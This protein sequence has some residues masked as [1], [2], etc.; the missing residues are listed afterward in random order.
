MP[1]EIPRLRIQANERRGAT[2]LLSIPFILPLFG[3]LFLMT[4]GV[5]G[6]SAPPSSGGA[7]PMEG[8][9]QQPTFDLQISK[10]DGVYYVTPGTVITYTI[11]YTNTWSSESPPFHVIECPPFNANVQGEENPDWTYKAP[12]YWRYPATD[13]SLAGGAS[14]SIAFTI[15]VPLAA[16]YG[17]QLDNRVSFSLDETD[18]ATPE[19]N[20]DRDTDVVVPGFNF[21]RFPLVT[22]A[23]AP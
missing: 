6:Y 20:A 1:R 18:D 22:K 19:D 10:S 9:P 21:C 12:C 3:L 11:Y 7:L 23:Y 15:T 8:H 5:A 13:I 16:S 14:G 17:T 2:A 4:Q